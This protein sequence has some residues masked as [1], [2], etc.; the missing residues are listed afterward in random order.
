MSTSLVEWVAPE[1]PRTAMVPALPIAAEEARRRPL[2]I[3]GM[4]AAIALLALLVGVLLPK[5]YTSSSSIVIEDNG[6]TSASPKAASGSK[7]Q[8]RAAQAK[9]IA[10]SRKVLKDVLATGGW[11]QD[12]P[13]AV[14][15]ERLMARIAKNV[16]IESPKQLPNLVKI[17]YSDEDPQR[18]YKVARRFGELIR[19]ETLAAEARDSRESYEFVSSQADQYYKRMVASRAKLS[20]YQQANPDARAGSLEDATL[21]VGELRR[22]VDMARMDLANARAE[23]AALSASLSRENPMGFMQPRSSHLQARLAEL[24]NEREK[25]MLSYTAQ[26]PDVM[27]VDSQ[28]RELQRDMRSGSNRGAMRLTV[29]SAGVPGASGINPVYAEL[30]RALADARSRAA[31]FASRV[32]QGESLLNRAQ[33]RSGEVVGVESEL[34]ELMRDYQSNHDVY[35]DLLKRR[36]AARVEMNLDAANR[37]LYIRVQDPATV[38]VEPDTGLRPMHVAI[39]GLI[40][41]AVLPVLMLFGWLRVDRRVRSPAQ[42][43]QIAGLPVL[44]TVPVQATRQRAVAQQHSSRMAMMLVLGVVLAYGLVLTLKWVFSA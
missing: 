36:E 12:N 21:Q 28:M 30:K 4:F 44:G 39:I 29:A 19:S 7:P 32:A 6:S 34:T 43:E 40:L 31:A 26:H 41:A 2:F 11:M 24:Q 1:S 8:P 33:A 20:A 42:I 13:T 14:E 37:G 38:P 25:L 22:A 10:L 3:A 23:E 15:Q 5:T 35:Q 18:A 16:V 27:R 9:E 17:S